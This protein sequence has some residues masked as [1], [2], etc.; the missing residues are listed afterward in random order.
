MTANDV[1]SESAPAL[2]LGKHLRPSSLR[3]AIATA[4]STGWSGG[5]GVNEV[6]KAEGQAIGWMARATRGKGESDV[7]RPTDPSR[8]HPASLSAIYGK[9]AQPLHTDGAHLI[10]PPRWLLL[11]S[12]AS[13]AVPTWLWSPAS[14]EESFDVREALFNGIFTVA[15]GS[16]SFLAPA[17]NHQLTRFDPGCMRP[18][19]GLANLTFEFLVSRSTAAVAHHWSMPNTFLLIDNYRVL[20]GRGDAATEPG[21]V[22]ERIA[23][24][25]PEGNVL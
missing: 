16:S 2:A 5:I 17:R 7:L 10:D 19:D 18:G 15:S 6:I 11:M 21:R 4:Q 23:F 22:L 20:H 1:R 9:G 14:D 25:L 8:A 3:D 24:D 13:S 12:A